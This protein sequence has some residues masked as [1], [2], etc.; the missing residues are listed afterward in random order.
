MKMKKSTD[1]ITRYIVGEYYVDF[2][3]KDDMWEAWLQHKSYG[4][5]ELMFGLPKE[6]TPKKMD[7]LFIVCN[8]LPEYMKQYW[9][10]RKAE[11][12]A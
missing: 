7:A 10:D 2:V 8:N 1:K 4:I 9:K 11:D 6:Q 5:S 3:E 12:C